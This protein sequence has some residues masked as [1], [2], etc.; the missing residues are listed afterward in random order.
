MLRERP[1]SAQGAIILVGGL[2]AGIR[3]LSKYEMAE[4][5]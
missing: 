5:L 4:R 3:W 2:G 1:F